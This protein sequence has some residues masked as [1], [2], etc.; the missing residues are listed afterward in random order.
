MIWRVEIKEKAG[1]GVPSGG[2]VLR[3]IADLGITSLTRVDVSHIYTI[4]AAFSEDQIL[5]AASRLLADPVTQDYRCFPL[6]RRAAGPLLS[7]NCTEIEVAHNPGVMDPVEAS[8]M[9]GLKDLGLEPV[10]WVRT[11]KKYYLYGSLTKRQADLIVEKVLSN[12][13]IQH[14]VKD[15]AASYGS[16]MTAGASK[17]T[18]FTVDILGASAKALLKL[19]MDGQLFLNREEMQAVQKYFRALGRNPTDCELETVAQTWSE[20]CHHKTFRGKIRYE[21]E[22]G[23]Q[24][25]VKIINNLLKSTIAKAT[26]DLA[27]PWCVSVFHDN[28]GVIRFDKEMNVCFKV[29]THNHPSALEP[30]GGA[31]TGIGGVIRDILGTGLGAKPVCNTDIFCFA[32]PDF[33]PEQLPA[34]TLHPKRIM[35]GVVSGV[36]DYG[37]K[38]G[39]PTVNGAILFDDGFVGNPLVYCGNVGLIP[40]G[41]EFKEVLKGDLIV[42]VGGR[43]GRDGIHGATFSSAELTDASEVVSSGA[44][45]IGDPIQEKKV[46]DCLLQA[47]DQD[48]YHAITDCGAG[49]LSSAVGEMGETLGAHVD[50]EKV[51]LKYQ[52][53]SYMEI[54]I[55][56]SQERMVLAVGP[57]NIDKLL[58]VFHSENV[59]AFV[60]GSF[61]GTGRLE[62]F[63]HG[64]QVCD[65][66]MAFLHNGIPDIT[67]KAVWKTPRLKTP[68]LKCPAD[69]TAGLLDVLAHYNVCSKEWVIRQY[70]HEVQ[71]GSVIKPLCG[72]QFDG[73]S[74]ASVIRPRLNSD[75]GLAISNGINVLYGKLDPYWMAAACIDEAVR[76]VVAVGG[77]PDRIAI[78]D[79]FCWGNP[80]KP[81]R[82]GGLVR[83]AQG[84]YKAAIAYGVPFISGKDSLY[85]EYTLNNKSIAIPGTLLI[86]AIGLVDDVNRCV[87]MDFKKAGSLIYLIGETYDELGGSIYYDTLERLGA[88]VP[89]VRFKKGKMIFDHLAQAV[90]QKLLL[91]LHDCSEGGLGVALAE[92]AFSGGLGATVTLKDVCFK[93]DGARDDSVLF[94]ESTSRFVAE[95]SPHKQKAFEKALGAVPCRC[96]GR[97]EESP[98]F[99][100]YGREDTVCV[101]VLISDL[102]E[103]WQKPLRW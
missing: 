66:D 89:Q 98:E 9:K 78:L 51:P 70:D 81:D 102:K 5:T 99:V 55:S 18:V 12:K 39:I 14:A 56:E 50:L 101:N 46:L 16:S 36:R 38:M 52:G 19:S 59:E 76:Q 87:T 3:D 53:L 44:V 15:P 37:N 25:K 80:D 73:P 67:K 85:N 82:L 41:K 94:S 45:Q 103:A 71:G 6:D 91:S 68:R 8:T 21:F 92:M 74:D 48:L 62:L 34:G 17:D 79:N 49:G 96:I 1:I 97:V 88:D 42:V 63:F 90:R 64:Q 28:A 23:G 22:E 10:E 57:R 26:L 24:K 61:P 95:V 83:A 2:G 29:E 93:G 75:Q 72:A 4:K 54:W 7:Q 33:P 30:F 27:K 31:N 32:P 20:H 58:D 84:C 11:A 60:I 86:S 47:R 77:N 69:L 35:K 43:T 40:K 100:I 65:L 13:L